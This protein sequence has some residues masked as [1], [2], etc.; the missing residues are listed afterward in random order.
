MIINEINFQRKKEVSYLA[1]P[2]NDSTKNIYDYILKQDTKIQLLEKEMQIIKSELLQFNQRDTLLQEEKEEDKKGGN[3]IKE[4]MISFNHD[5]DAINEIKEIISN[6]ICTEDYVCPFMLQLKNSFIDMQSTAEKNTISIEKKL[7]QLEDKLNNISN[8]NTTITSNKE[9]KNITTKEYKIIDSIYIDLISK[10]AKTQEA[11][12]NNCKSELLSKIIIIQKRL[13]EFD[14]DFDKLIDSLKTQFQNVNE[15][16]LEQK[17]DKEKHSTKDDNNQNLNPE[18]I[19]DIF[20]TIN[21]LKEKNQRNEHII[22]SLSQIRKDPIEK[23]TL[24]NMMAKEVISLRKEINADFELINSK[25]LNELQSQANDISDIY[26][27]IRSQTNQINK[28]DNFNEIGDNFMFLAHQLEQ[29][30][31]IE[32]LNYALESQSKI[33]DALCLAYRIGR[34]SW[35]NGRID[36][37]GII[38]W[39]MMNINTAID[40]FKWNNENG[41]IIIK[42]KGIYKIVTGLICTSNIEFCIYINNTAIINNNDS[43]NQ[44]YS[45]NNMLLLNQYIPLSEGS[46]IKIG[47][48]IENYKD[49]SNINAESF[50]EIRAVL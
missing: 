6:I 13:N 24:T 37:K 7:S 2:S 29:K 22:A 18:I 34:W 44:C 45:I 31:N 36:E 50:L 46:I 49:L 12:I 16:I 30:A 11:S 41:T 47:I 27:I 21:Q 43:S 20:T 14:Q 33:N 5:K 32:H 35:S 3:R 19:H 26:T 28:G 10:H 40:N 39:T 1:Q 25:I 42:T 15:M 17:Q 48:L 9:E 8:N 23:D 38:I 4:E